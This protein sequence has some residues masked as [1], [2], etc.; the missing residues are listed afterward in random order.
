MQNILISAKYT[1]TKKAENRK[2]INSPVELK[3]T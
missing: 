2:I 1:S 3:E